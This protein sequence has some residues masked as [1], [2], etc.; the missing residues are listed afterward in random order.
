VL[1]IL[2]STHQQPEQNLNK[3]LKFLIFITKKQITRSNQAYLNSKISI[4][5]IKIKMFCHNNHLISEI[6]RFNSSHIKTTPYYK[7][8]SYSLK[9]IFNS[10]SLFQQFALDKILI[11][12]VKTI[13]STTSKFVY[14]N[15]FNQ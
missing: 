9:R 4:K 10:F 8:K 12:L 1:G 11:D 5:N 14:F 6:L 3:N 2:N 15:M 13:N 7:S